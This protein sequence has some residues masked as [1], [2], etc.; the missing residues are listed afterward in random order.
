MWSGWDLSWS[1]SILD[2]SILEKFSLQNTRSH[3][4]T[5]FTL[6]RFGSWVRGRVD[7]SI[8]IKFSTLKKN[9]D[10]SK[11]FNW[12]NMW[13]TSQCANYVGK[14]VSSL[15]TRH[16]SPRT[17]SITLTPHLSEGTFPLEKQILHVDE[18]TFRSA[19]SSF[20]CVYVST[21]EGLYSSWIGLVGPMRPLRI[22]EQIERATPPGSRLSISAQNHSF[23]NIWLSRENLR[24][25][26]SRVY[27]PIKFKY[28]RFNKSFPLHWTAIIFSNT[29][30]FL[31]YRSTNICEIY[32]PYAWNKNMF[33]IIH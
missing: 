16:G 24:S 13:L 30:N 27:C 19:D 8:V 21:W 25:L 3:F 7:R 28:H 29:N 14:H 15:V 33:W 31:Y 20:R 17:R 12:P 6:A 9:S 26:G 1:S 18:L 11:I 32:I 10:N 5:R 22:F 4:F 23:F 2:R